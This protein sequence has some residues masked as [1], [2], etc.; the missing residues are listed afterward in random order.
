MLGWHPAVTEL[1]MYL[2]RER[3]VPE[4][5]SLS[6][7]KAPLGWFEVGSASRSG[8]GDCFVFVFFS[9]VLF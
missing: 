2:E 3:E 9:E 5:R 4:T 8:V 1:G 6:H 7:Q